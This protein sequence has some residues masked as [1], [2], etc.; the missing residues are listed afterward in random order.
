M[1]E[2]C[3]LNSFQWEGTDEYRTDSPP[4]E[5]PEMARG[6][7]RLPGGTTGPMDLGDARAEPEV[8]GN[9]ENNNASLTHVPRSLCQC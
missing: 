3:L 1:K 8:R 4:I 6:A 2:G 7:F 5:C 9:Y